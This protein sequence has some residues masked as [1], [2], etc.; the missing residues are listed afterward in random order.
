[1]ATTAPEPLLAELETL[2]GPRG[3]SRDAA[4]LEPWLRDW[5]GRYRG[6]AP[7]LL[8]PCDT[9]QVQALV[10]AC[11]RYRMPLVPQGGN[12]SLMGGATPP[13]SGALLLSLRRMNRIRI[14]SPDDNMLV[15]E[16]G[17]V[18]ASVHEAAS[19]ARRRFP[20][21]LAAKG[22]ATLGGLVS[23]NAGGTQVLR[24]G[25]MRSLVLGL[26]AVLPDGSLFDSLSALRKDNRGYDLRQL[27]IGAEGTL[28]VVTAASLRLVAA[29]G[30]RGVAWVGLASPEDALA[31]LR[32]LEARVGDAVESFE[33]MPADALALVL[34]H[35]PGTRAPL[36][37]EHRWHV[38]VEAVAP[39]SGP[40]AA[41]LLTE[42]LAEA[43]ERGLAADAVVAGSEAQAE[44]LWRLRETIAEAERQEGQA[45][46]HD[47]SVPV[48]AMPAFIEK[49]SM[50]VE[51]RF[52]GTKVVAFGHLGDGN[53]HFNV[54]PPRGDDSGRWIAGTGP[55]VTVFVHDLV[56]A[57]AGSISAEHGIGQAKLA[58]L[59]RTASPVALRTQRAIKAALD[60]LGIMNPGKL[61][62]PET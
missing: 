44:E 40:D 31:L 53:V 4:A 5:R 8:S 56:S 23:T 50:E 52:Q 42:A 54:L 15:A 13:E 38:L 25:P 18:L 45:L 14:V 27:L 17:V 16:A 47:I 9:A 33:L 30:S 2:L 29:A 1:M 3:F 61:V 20:L 35:I 55:A 36:A 62:A 22:S 49:A 12:T 43:L 39:Q 57:A 28:G 34:R 37:G 19:Q 11:A 24:Y 10:T 26:E 41:V 58:E 46:K 60:P 48:S 32:Q 6:T 51:A 21:S 59:A 7:A